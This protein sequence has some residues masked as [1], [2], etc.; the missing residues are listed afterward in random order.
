MLRAQGGV[1]E[2]GP[3]E[4]GPG[5]FWVS[6][7]DHVGGTEVLVGNVNRYFVSLANGCYDGF[8]ICD[9]YDE[10]SNTFF[11]MYVYDFLFIFW[12]YF[13]LLY[14]LS[15]FQIVILKY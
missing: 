4:Q 10:Y 2:R 8:G 15:Y 12:F 13:I 11:F 1:E 6:S 9:V 5:R 3:A 14:I 7:D